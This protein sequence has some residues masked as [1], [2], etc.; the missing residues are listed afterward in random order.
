MEITQQL[1]KL[2]DQ[3]FKYRYAVLVL[4]VGVALMLIPSIES[5]TA[6]QE[7]KTDPVVVE[8]DPQEQLAALL[9][10]LQGAGKVEV[11]LSIAT[12]SETQY[13]SDIQ[14]H[15]DSTQQNTVIIT[16]GNRNESPLVS[17]VDPPRYQGAIILCQGADSAAV[18]LAIVEAVSNFTGLGADQIAVLK[19]K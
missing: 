7:I 5:P 19:M 3:I 12:G 10:K 15:T 1:Q 13:H 17:R 18:R 11:L 14:G 8:A 2:W 16:D 6:A 9:S 4:L